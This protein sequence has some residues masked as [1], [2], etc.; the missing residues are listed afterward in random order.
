[1]DYITEVT[2]PRLNKVITGEQGGISQSINWQSG[3]D[4]IYCELMPYNEV[5]MERIQSAESSEELLNILDEMSSESF[6]N[7]YINPEF[8]EA[9]ADSFI[10][11]DDVGKQKQLLAELLDKNQLYVH[12]SE[13][14][15][16][17]FEVSEADKALNT[18][19]YGGDDDA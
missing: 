14:E 1:M 11:I 2:V 9:A 19:F 8:P 3:G 12:L 17:R 16:E 4:F 7:W 10:E 15:D 5:F 13:I 18:D 6:L